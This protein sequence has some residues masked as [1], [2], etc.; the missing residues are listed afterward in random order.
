MAFF[1][2][3]Q[4]SI[5]LNEAYL[6]A[7]GLVLTLTLKELYM[8][9]C[10]L[11][12]FQM[13][14]KIRVAICSLVY[15]KSLRLSQVSLTELSS[16]RIIT[17]VSKDIYTLDGAIFYGNELWI[18]VLQVIALTYVIYKSVDY[19]AFVGVGFML[20]IIPIQCEY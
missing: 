16:G 13:G 4:T 10:Y 11:Y 2:S 5:K 8:H 14:T 18:G 1:T 6:Y 15:R 9:N 19:S 12:L 20:V 17:L 7:T 3:N